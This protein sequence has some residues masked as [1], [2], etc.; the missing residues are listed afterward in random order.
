MS[1]N[2]YKILVVED[3]PSITS[4]IQAVLEAND[5]Q[6]LTASLCRQGILMCASHTPDLVMLDLGLP[7]MDGEEFIPPGPQQQ[8]GAH[9]GTVRPDGGIGQG[10]RPGSGGQRLHHQ[11]LRHRGAAGPG[12]GRPCG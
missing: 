9:C 1:N 5:F 10:L 8:S 4:F 11:A 3:D 6:V 12:S 7:D 2:K